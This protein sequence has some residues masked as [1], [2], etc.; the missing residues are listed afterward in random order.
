MGNSSLTAW[1]KVCGTP[2]TFSFENIPCRLNW[3]AF[4]GVDSASLGAISTSPLDEEG[5]EEDALRGAPF[6]SNDNILPIGTYWFPCCLLQ[7]F[8]QDTA[9]FLMTLL[10]QGPLEKIGGYCK[11]KFVNPP[12]GKVF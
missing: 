3:T 2:C 7:F 4:Q 10:P 11:T 8:A 12:R 6:P 1:P 9:S 5:E